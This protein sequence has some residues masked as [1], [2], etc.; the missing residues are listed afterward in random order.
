MSRH[1]FLNLATRLLGLKFDV[2]R[3]VC[4]FPSMFLPRMSG[5]TIKGQTNQP[6]EYSDKAPGDFWSFTHKPGSGHPTKS[7]IQTDMDKIYTINHITE[8]TF[9]TRSYSATTIRLSLDC[10]VS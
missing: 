5:W 3:Q 4:H 9:P 10:G 7:N 1:A 8:K 2:I 6:H